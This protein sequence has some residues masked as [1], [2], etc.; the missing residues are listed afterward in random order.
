MKNNLIKKITLLIF[1]I[2]LEACTDPYALQTSSFEDALVVEATLTNQYKKQEIKLSRTYRLEENG[3]K[4]EEGATIFVTDNLGNIFNFIE[5]SGVY[6]SITEFQ[7]LPNRTYQLNVK[8]HDGK[9]YTST[10]EALTPVNEIQNLTTSV[11]EK[12]GIKGVDIIVNAFDPTFSSKYY[13]YEYD[14]TYKIIAPYWINQKANVNY[15]APGSIPEG[16]IV[17]ALR[18]EEARTCYSN[19]K[20]NELLLTNTA[21]LSE[22]RVYYPVRFI[23]NQNHIIMHRYSILV[24]QYVQNLAA[25]TFYEVLKK[26]SG[27]GGNILSQNQPGFFSGNIKS[28]DNPNEKVIGFFSVSSYSEKRIFFNFEDLFPNDLQPDYPF[29]CGSDSENGYLFCFTPSYTLDCKGHEAL[30]SLYY[31]TKSLYG[32]LDYGNGYPTYLL[33][34]IQCGDCTSFSSNIKPTFW[35][36]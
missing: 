35:I 33:C 30:E 21:N 31:E 26:M 18:T 1:T 24:K 15:F 28:I 19:S 13:R 34:P 32:Q 12:D 16:E 25:Q 36:D 22:D 6:K 27:S 5:E 9:S 29:K 4:I 20:S 11:I 17:L 23:S 7:A 8:T 14:E 3:P 2:L 10:N